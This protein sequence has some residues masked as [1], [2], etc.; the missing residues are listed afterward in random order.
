MKN[1]TSFGL[2]LNLTP[3][4]RRRD[5]TVKIIQSIDMAM[6]GISGRGGTW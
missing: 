3:N 5:R 6:M 4:L 1:S 2:L